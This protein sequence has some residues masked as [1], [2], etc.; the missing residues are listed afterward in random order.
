MKWIFDE[1]DCSNGGDGDAGGGDD[2]C[3]GNRSGG[4]C[5]DCGSTVTVAMVMAV[6]VVVGTVIIV[7]VVMV[8]IVVWR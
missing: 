2:S 3:L 5:V 7:T 4:D 8:M 6:A 1:D